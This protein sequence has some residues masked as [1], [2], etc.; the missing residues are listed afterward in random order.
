MVLFYQTLANKIK[1]RLFFWNKRTAGTKLM[2]LGHTVF[3]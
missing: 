2:S 3:A 1:A